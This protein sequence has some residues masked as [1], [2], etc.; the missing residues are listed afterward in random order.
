M[1]YGIIIITRHNITYWQSDI[2]KI[3]RL[4]IATRR[5][6]RQC[7]RLPQRQ[8]DR[9]GANQTTLCVSHSL[10]AYS[11]PDSQSVSVGPD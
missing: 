2:G 4:A 3:G 10:S 11:A 5:W 6:H 1:E 9:R 8:G 7:P